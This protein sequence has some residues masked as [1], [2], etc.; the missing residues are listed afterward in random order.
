MNARQLSTV[1]L[2]VLAGASALAILALPQA[3]AQ[4][5]DP[6]SA[7][8]RT[9]QPRGLLRVQP[10]GPQGA[11]DEFDAGEWRAALADL[12]LDRRLASFERLVTR[13]RRGGAAQAFLDEAAL[14]SDDLAWTARLALRE[15]RSS[16][17][18]SPFDVWSG[19]SDLDEFERML[20][21]FTQRVAPGWNRKVDPLVIPFPGLQGQT[22]VLPGSGTSRSR[23]VEIQ[24]GADGWTIKVTED[25]D[26]DEST[27]EYSGKTLE[28]ILEANPALK[29]EVGISGSLVGPGLSF[30]IGSPADQ[31]FDFDALFGNLGVRRLAPA[32]PGASHPRGQIRTDIL[33]VIARP[34]TAEEGGAGL[35]VRS[36]VP[37]SIAALLG[38]QG[39]DVLLEVNG[40][41]LHAIDDVT[42]ALAQ[43]GESGQVAA[44][45]L[46]AQGRRRT[47][48]WHP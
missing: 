2:P 4:A 23:R 32:L 26:G 30:R 15:V 22:P 24:N 9:A 31:T 45:W 11:D 37:G 36:T 40:R 3:L 16:R 43:R 13:A 39:G 14:G 20:E 46:D 47:G 1:A 33:G 44:S 10:A 6:T 18:R 12:D 38:I 25:D 7:G 5:G 28:E 42:Q 48:T 27:R 34:A 21:D 17:P 41:E 35:L 29:D 8:A 19:A